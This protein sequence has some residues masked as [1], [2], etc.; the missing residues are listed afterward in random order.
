MTR[1]RFLTTALLAVFCILGGTTTMASQ[2]ELERATL[3]GGCFWCIE[4]VFEEVAGVHGAESGYAGGEDEVFNGKKIDIAKRVLK[5]AIRNLPEEVFFT[6]IVFNHKVQALR[7]K[8][9][10]ANQDN[11]NQIYLALNDIQPKGATYTYGALD[12]TFQMAG[13]GLKDKFYD[14]GVDTIFLLSDGAPTTDSP[15]K[16]EPMEPETILAQVS[17]WNQLKRI[18]IHAICIDP[19]IGSGSFVRF[20]KALAR[21]HSGTYREIGGDGRMSTP[22]DR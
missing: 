1:Q 9:L 2:P 20:M 13:R 12:M 8:A 14:P 15:D 17:D 4:A 5:Q 22:L 3:G 21:E 18:Q 16:A 10:E 6:V 11:K 19:R 7:G